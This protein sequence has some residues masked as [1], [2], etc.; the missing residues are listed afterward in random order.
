MLN[1]GTT[2]AAK[3]GHVELI[4]GNSPAFQPQEEHLRAVLRSWHRSSGSGARLR[5]R[6]RA[7][8]AE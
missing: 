5:A 3:L 4:L 6:V 2:E 8:E 1:K 7:Q